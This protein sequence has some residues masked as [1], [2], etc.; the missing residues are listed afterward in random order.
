[1]AVKSLLVRLAV[2]GAVAVVLGACT[3]TTGSSTTD[4]GPLV[5]TPYLTLSDADQVA[6]TFFIAWEKA[7]YTTMYNL[8]SPHS[9][10]A[11]TEED[12]RNEY[13]VAATQITQTALATTILSSLRQGSTAA[14]QYDVTFS[15]GMFGEISDPGRT[16]RLIETSDGWRIAWSRM[17]IFPELAAGARLERIQTL[18][19]RGNIYDRNGQVLVGQ[20]GRAVGLYIVRQ[21]LTDEAAC[22]DLLARI[23]RRD[24]ADL[25]RQFTNFALETRF[26]V[27]EID[28][29]T[30]Q[31]EA[32][33]LRELCDIGDDD[34]DTATRPTRRYY[35][36][37]APHLIG[38]V[39]QIQTEQLAEY[40]RRGY[41]QD[42]L[43]GQTGIEKAYEDVLAGKPGGQ[44]V[45]IAP[46]GETIRK[47]A[48][49]SAAPGQSVYLTIDRNLQEAVQNA[50][51]EA[52]G[53]ATE[54]W[55]P[56]SPGAAAVVMNVKT[57]EILAMASY[58]W[59]DPSLFN[60]DSPMW[61]R[62]QRI[63]D[64]RNSW[65]TPLLNRVTMGKYPAGS[66]FKI[67]SSAAGLDSGVYTPST[68]YTCTGTWYGE[69]YGDGRPYRTD[70][71]P[72]GH[73]LLDFPR[74]LTVSSDP[75]F[76][77]LGVALHGKDPEL[78]TK[79]AYKMGLGVPTGQ[80]DLPEEVGQ[81]PNKELIFRTNARSWNI[82]D[83][84]NMVIGQGEMQITPLQ[85]TRM[86]AAVANGGSL[87]RPQFVKEVGLIGEE[88]SYVATPTSTDTLDFAPE[89]FTTIRRGMCDVTLRPEGTA[90]YMF[91]E[92]YDWQQTDVVIC[93]KTG[94]AETGGEN[95]KP[96]AWFVA[97]TPQD[98][99]EI[100]ITVIVENSC[101]G[102][103]V[104][105]PIVR[106]I[107]EDYY[108]M[109]HGA[110]PP[111]WE[112][113]CVTLGE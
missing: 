99:P 25:Q 12:F 28:P 102:S 5:P 9:R 43:I 27:D 72:D 91:Q 111:L 68:T 45:I 92:W 95:V 62:E 11:Y 106:R 87:W 10:D 14:V 24:V 107:V 66:V 22:I 109:P 88:P 52:Y 93:G 94:T 19:N 112:S 20:E 33:N 61:D 74:A 41:P 110:W 17:D 81:V 77:Q 7:D 49:S 47:I 57:G 80:E 2:F 65:R 70:W 59:F 79:Y 58:P 1:M 53:A 101:E 32:A 18:P 90:R 96:Q 40:Q 6:G 29:D 55:S 48:E 76:W 21:D 38:Y 84:L 37:L 83:T 46:T 108:G 54:T 3:N 16:L 89:T 50:L 104:A 15:T 35:G 105:A 56:T 13:D 36:D 26:V 69:Q 51:W 60:P 8:I 64:L 86:V 67:V 63:T 75:Y 103:E 98:D 44:L 31:A 73:G 34:Y 71:K 113:G 4:S 30:F 97:F 39:G 23:T 85:I 82:S 100:A 42:A 78:L